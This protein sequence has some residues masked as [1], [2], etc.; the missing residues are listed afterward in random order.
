MVSRNLL[1]IDLHFGDLTC[2]LFDIVLSNKSI[3]VEVQFVKGLSGTLE[4][5]ILAVLGSFVALKNISILMP[6]LYIV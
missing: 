5:L 6:S 4:L 2:T 3:P 1:P